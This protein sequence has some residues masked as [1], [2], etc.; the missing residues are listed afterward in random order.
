MANFFPELSRSPE[1]SHADLGGSTRD[2]ACLSVW[3]DKL[4]LLFGH[5]FN[6]QCLPVLCFSVLSIIGLQ[7]IVLYDYALWFL[8][9]PFKYANLCNLCSDIST[10]ND[11]GISL[12]KMRQ[13]KIQFHNFTSSPLHNNIPL[14]CLTQI[15]ITCLN[16]CIVREANI[17]AQHTISLE[18]NLK[19]KFEN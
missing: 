12:G 15:T 17:D 6:L 7:K 16:L 8:V 11:F 5:L 2:E 4:G 1:L 18:L 10:K 19:I 9:S 14:C 3:T 13:T